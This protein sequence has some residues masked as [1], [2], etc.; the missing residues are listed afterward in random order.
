VTLVVLLCVGS[1]EV[2]LEIFFK[3]SRT[4]LAVFLDGGHRHDVSQ[5][6]QGIITRHSTHEHVSTL[7]LVLREMSIAMPKGMGRTSLT[8]HDKALATAQRQW[9]NR[10]IS[11]V[12]GPVLSHTVHA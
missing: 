9:Q 7:G 2:R 11:N 4:L 1:T 5:R 10:E 8:A 6:L 3:D 12:G